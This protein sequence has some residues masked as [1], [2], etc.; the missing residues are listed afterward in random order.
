MDERKKRRDA[1]MGMLAA[2][3]SVL[4]GMGAILASA[5]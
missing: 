5:G 2:T 1:Q 3:D 4:R